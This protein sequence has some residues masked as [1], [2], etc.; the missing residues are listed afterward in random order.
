M[1]LSSSYHRQSYPVISLKFKVLN[2]C[3]CLIYAF[4][5]F[6]KIINTLRSLILNIVAEFDR[7]EL[8]ENSDV[9]EA[10]CSV[11]SEKLCERSC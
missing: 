3:C 5:Y 10:L 9:K 2:S 1:D 6:K 4:Y 11:E 7:V 8:A